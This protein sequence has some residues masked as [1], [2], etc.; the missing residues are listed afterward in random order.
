MER[1]TKRE[2]IIM[3]VKD[4]TKYC[5]CEDEYAGEPQDSVEAAVHDYLDCNGYDGYSSLERSQ[6]L[7]N[8]VEIGH[9]AYFVPDVDGEQVIE[10][11]IN[12][13]PDEIYD[14]SEDYLS[15]VK[16]E[17]IQELSDE[18]TKVFRNWEKRYG[19]ENTMHVVEET[20]TYEIKDYVN[21]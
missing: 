5:W 3:L 15:N 7:D 2:R 9:P 18:L 19:Y 4:E 12:Y 16:Y 13:M 20:K 21:E 14:H 10:H 11:V 17:H 8:G 1:T 6:L